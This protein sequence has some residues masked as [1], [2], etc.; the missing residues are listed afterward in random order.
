VGLYDADVEKMKNENDCRMIVPAKSSPY[1]VQFVPGTRYHV[2]R[3]NVAELTTGLARVILTMRA[4]FDIVVS[5]S[6]T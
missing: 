1:Y 6:F 4:R 3:A 5:S 2:S